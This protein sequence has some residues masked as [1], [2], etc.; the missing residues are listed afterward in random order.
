[1]VAHKC[2][3]QSTKSMGLVRRGLE[4]AC[5]NHHHGVLVGERHTGIQ[6]Y[7]LLSSTA[8]NNVQNIAFKRN[9]HLNY[10]YLLLLNLVGQAAVDPS[11]C[12]GSR[13]L[14][15]LQSHI[16]K[17]S[18]FSHLL[19]DTSASY[20]MCVCQYDSPTQNVSQNAKRSRSSEV[21]G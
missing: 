15:I 5:S 13:R 2:P 17:F 9:A 10:C 21:D 16:G 6:L 3:I 8:G 11:L 18:I 1:M 14:P 20:C 19:A 7:N 12:T 4:D